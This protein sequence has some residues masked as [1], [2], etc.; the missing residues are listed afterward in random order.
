MAADKNFLGIPIEGEPI[1]S[2]ANRVAQRP[3][4]ELQEALAELIQYEDFEGLRWKQY[5]PY[6]NDGDPCVFGIGDVYCRVK[7][8]PYDPDQEGGWEEEDNFY[9]PHNS[10]GDD[11]EVDAVLGKMTGR[12]YDY[13]TRTYTDGEWVVQPQNPELVHQLQKCAGM[14]TSGAFNDALLQTFGDHAKITIR[15]DNIELETYEHD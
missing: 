1:Y 12:K 8:L 2:S 14:I 3:I 7:G 6:F 13:K 5:T 11:P 10:Y 9:S 15:K 4:E